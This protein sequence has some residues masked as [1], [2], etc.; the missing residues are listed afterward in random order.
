MSAGIAVKAA[1]PGPGAEQC[2]LVS[3]ISVPDLPSWLVERRRIDQLIG[4]GARRPL[5]VVTGPPGAGK[6][7]AIASWANG[8]TGHEPHA[9]M[10]VDRY[11]NQPETFWCHLVEALIRAGL[12][13]ARPSQICAQA[14]SADRGFLSGLVSALAECDPPVVLVLDDIHLL[15]KPEPL[16]DL[17]YVVQH[18]GGRLRLIVASRLDPLLPLHRF[19][20]AGNLTEV[21]SADLAFTVA[22]ARALLAQHD[23][24]LSEPALQMLTGRAEGWAAVLGCSRPPCRRP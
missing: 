1:Q 13:L 19:R 21:R 18:A 15:T 7:V 5:T 20:L 11:D 9:W 2:L 4:D 6:T 10:T 17:A 12:P 8:R 14:D 16:D 23:I 3:K 24:S 22:E